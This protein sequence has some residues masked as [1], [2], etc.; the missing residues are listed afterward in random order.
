MLSP[1]VTTGFSLSDCRI[2][3]CYSLRHYRPF[4][5]TVEPLIMD[6]PSSGHLPNNGQDFV[7]QPYFPL[8][9]YKTN[10]PRVDTSLL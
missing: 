5:I 7:H 2:Q 9:L 3:L 4:A 8:L 1:E 10:L 6:I